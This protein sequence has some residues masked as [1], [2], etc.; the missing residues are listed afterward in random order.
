MIDGKVAFSKFVAKILYIYH[1]YL[2]ITGTVLS[3]R[4]PL[5]LGYVDLCL[6]T[7]SEQ[8]N[9]LFEWVYH[10]HLY[11]PHTSEP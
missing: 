2:Q 6:E 9:V 7:F 1:K 4:R 10:L 5:D 3:R 8:I 11:S